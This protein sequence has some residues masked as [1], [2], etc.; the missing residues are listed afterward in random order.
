MN[1][2]CLISNFVSVIVLSLGFNFQIYQDAHELANS[3]RKANEGWK[4]KLIH[5]FIRR[6]GGRMMWEKNKSTTPSLA[7]PLALNLNKIGSFSEKDDMR[8]GDIE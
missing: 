2:A 3:S 4:R 1:F 6:K 5:D 8:F 7:F